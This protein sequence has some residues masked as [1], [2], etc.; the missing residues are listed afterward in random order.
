M[1]RFSQVRCQTC[2]AP[3]ATRC[4]NLGSVGDTGSLPNNY[5]CSLRR[6]N[7]SG[8][9]MGSLHRTWT[10]L[11][12]SSYWF[13][14]FSTNGLAPTRTRA[15]ATRVARLGSCSSTIEL[16]P[17]GYCRFYE[18]SLIVRKSTAFGSRL[19]ARRTVSL[20]PHAGQAGS[21]CDCRTCGRRRIPS[22]ARASDSPSPA[23][24]R[25]SARMP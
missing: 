13:R 5:S 22:P 10:T 2:R 7:R 15:Y 14:Q 23:S 9:D 17:R 16:H 18:Y 24:G 6:I 4:R 3:L 8:S 1:E 21:H 20:H 25:R 12:S 19:S 11:L